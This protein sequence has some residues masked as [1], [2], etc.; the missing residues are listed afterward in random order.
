MNGL[1]TV[2]ESSHSKIRALVGKGRN[3]DGD[4]RT[5]VGVSEIAVVK[6]RSEGKVRFARIRFQS[7]AELYCGFATPGDSAVYYEPVKIELS[8]PQPAAICRKE[9]RESRAI[10]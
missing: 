9:Q 6:V 3:G 10:A 2:D 1:T 8:S 4:A 5:G 7:K